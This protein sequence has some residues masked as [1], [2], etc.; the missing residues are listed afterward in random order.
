MIISRTPLRMSFVGG[1]SDLPVFY[2]K[3]G[4]AVVSTAIDQCVYITVNQKFDEKIRVSYSKTEE[5]RSVDR[6]KHPLVREAM[7]LVGIEGGIEITSIADIPGRGSGLGSSSSFTVGLLHALHA[8]AERYASA[9]QL[10]REACQIEI[11]RCGE[12]IGKQD[13]Y[14]AAYG[15]FNFI[16]FNPD[17]SVSVEPILCRRETIEAIQRGIVTFYTGIT[18]SASAILKDQQQVVANE[19]AKQKVMLRMVQLARDLKA[20]LQRNNLTAFGEIIHEGWRLKKSLTGGITTDQIDAWY[21]KAR[22][23]GAVGGKLLGA[24]TGGFLMFYAPPD[25]HE[26]IARALGDLRRVDFRF[27]PQGSKIIFVH[28]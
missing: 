6:I 25:R 2:R 20:E 28:H 7:K 21:E 8:Y 24:G 13:Q 5:A 4:G 19:K 27:E 10:A 11:E 15:G 14:A 26:A 12:P 17:D 23:A 3:H 1:G 9:E 22:R 16:E 18:R